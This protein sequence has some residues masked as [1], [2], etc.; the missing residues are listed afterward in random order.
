[1]TALDFKRSLLNFKLKNSSVTE[2]NM[3]AKVIANS[4][5]DG[6]FRT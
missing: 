6:F 2:R 1:M 4:F 5:C 3:K